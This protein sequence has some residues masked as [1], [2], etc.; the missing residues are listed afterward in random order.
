MLTNALRKLKRQ[1]A[2]SS[3]VVASVSWLRNRKRRSFAE[4]ESR[5]AGAHGLE[6]GG[7]SK[8]FSQRGPFPVYSVVAS[9]DNVNFSDANFW[10][11]IPAGM[12]FQFDEKKQ[13]GQQIIADA[14]DLSVI[15]DETYD[16]VIS[17]HVIEHLANPIRGLKEWQR[18]L[19]PGGMM[20]VV[21]PDKRF[22]YDRNRP[23]TPLSHILEDFAFNTPEDDDTHL[24]EVIRL[25][26]LT[27]DG[28]VSSFDEHRARTLNNAVTRIT[29]HHVFDIDLL[30]GLLVAADFTILA[31]DVFRPYHLLAVAQ[32]AKLAAE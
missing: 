15:A 30:L 23:V 22:T 14:V 9:L 6:I 18:I 10:S 32:K 12:N 1:T 26:D 21:A 13:P 27:N 24:E 11:T 5:I 29:H 3:L 17:S 16:L 20:I 2:R 28:T 7:P 31:Q 8:I 25:H 19:K 4:V